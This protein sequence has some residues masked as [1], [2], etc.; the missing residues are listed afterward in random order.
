VVEKQLV[1]PERTSPEQ[2]EPVQL[3]KNYLPLRP[4]L[5]VSAFYSGT[6]KISVEAGKGGQN[7]QPTSESDGEIKGEGAPGVALDI[8]SAPDD[9]WGYM[10]GASYEGKSHF[11]SMVLSNSGTDYYFAFQPRVPELTLL[12][13]YANFVYRWDRIYI[14]FG[15]NYTFPYLNYPESTTAGKFMFKPGLGGQLGVG[16]FL[17]T[18]LSAEITYRQVTLSGSWRGTLN[19]A[20]TFFDYDYIHQTG[21]QLRLRLSL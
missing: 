20:A 19:G 2:L 21:I 14:L 6:G 11:K 3:K 17:L 4:T 16:Y 12:S 10:I 18:R 1:A 15:L 9:A 13:P 8:M 7:G 5:G